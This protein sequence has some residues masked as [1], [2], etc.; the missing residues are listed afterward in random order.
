MSDVN[1]A[2]RSAEILNNCLYANIATSRNDVPWN[3]PATAL[4]DNELNFYWSSWRLAEHSRNIAANSS[5]FMTFYDSTRAR[6]TNNLRCL[7]LQCVAREVSD[8][9]EARKAFGL[10]YPGESVEL[11][12]PLDEGVKRFYCAEPKQAWLNCLSE[13]ELEPDTLKMRTE[14][15]LDELRQALR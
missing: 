6:G 14:V 12:N 8:P 2:K 13:K 9:E 11:T 5:I 3:T 4:P 15:P 7:Y 10:L 1:L